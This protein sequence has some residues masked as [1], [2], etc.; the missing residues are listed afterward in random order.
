V[1]RSSTALR[2]RIGTAAR[3]AVLERYTWEHTWGKALEE[4][5][6]RTRGPASKST[7]ESPVSPR[8]GA[9]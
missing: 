3:R 5:G 2:D 8:N 4:I 9:R 7:P 1:Y 6:E